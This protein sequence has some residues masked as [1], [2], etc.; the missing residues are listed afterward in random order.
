GVEFATPGVSSPGMEVSRRTD[1][2]EVVA[3]WMVDTIPDLKYAETGHRGFMVLTAT[4]DECRSTW[5]FVSTV[6][7]RQYTLSEGATVRTLPGSAQRALLPL[8]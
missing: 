8:A 3:Q 5:Y 7:S 6:K 4:R 1:A 2:P